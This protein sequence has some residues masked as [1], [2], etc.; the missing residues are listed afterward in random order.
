VQRVRHGLQICLQVAV[1]AFGGVIGIAGLFG[2]HGEYQQISWNISPRP[3]TGRKTHTERIY[4]RVAELLQLSQSDALIIEE[5]SGPSA[6]TGTVSRSTMP[7]SDD[8]ILAP[9]G[10]IVKKKYRVVRI[11]L[12]SVQMENV[13]NK[14]QQ[15]L[16]LAEDAGANMSN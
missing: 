1:K 5:E 9:E 8:I 4:T 16:P 14:K 7:R 13:D 15:S 11:N 12:T 2:I 3:L 6:G 10:G